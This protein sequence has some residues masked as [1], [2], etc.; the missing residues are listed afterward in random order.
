MTAVPLWAWAATL[1]VLAVLIVI[2]LVLTRKG[3]AG[4]R[5]A[6]V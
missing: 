6:A 3:E 5:A 2:D 1:A 4:L